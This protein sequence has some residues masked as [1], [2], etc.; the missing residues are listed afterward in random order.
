VPEGPVS[1]RALSFPVGGSKKLKGIIATGTGTLTKNGS[2]TLTV[3]GVDPGPNLISVVAVTLLCNGSLRS[4]ADAVNIALG[5]TL[6]EGVS[7]RVSK[8]TPRLAAETEQSVYAR[9]R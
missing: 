9:A 6:A 5:T 8:R 2:G 1:K 4:N 7:A 3:T